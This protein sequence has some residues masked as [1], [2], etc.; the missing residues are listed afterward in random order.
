MLII[1]NF[2]VFR[3]QVSP[4][5][6]SFDNFSKGPVEENSLFGNKLSGESLYLKTFVSILTVGIFV[7]EPSFLFN[8][9]M[10]E[11]MLINNPRFHFFCHRHMLI[12]NSKYDLFCHCHTQRRH[13]DFTKHKWKHSSFGTCIRNML[14]PKLQKLLMIKLPI[15]FRYQDS[16]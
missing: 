12:R 16:T 15:V 9:F 2:R 5:S 6:D 14:L 10:F 11:L 13:I 4:R 8:Y 3:T 1:P 7:E